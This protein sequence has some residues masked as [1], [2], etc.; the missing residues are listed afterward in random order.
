MSN[1]LSARKLRGDYKLA[2]VLIP[3]A[4]NVSELVKL[5][6]RGSVCILALAADLLCRLF[7]LG[8]LP[9]NCFMLLRRVHVQAWYGRLSHLHRVQSLLLQHVA[10]R[11][12]LLGVLRHYGRCGHWV[13]QLR[14]PALSLLLDEKLLPVLVF[15]FL[16]YVCKHGQLGTC[17]LIPFLVV[18]QSCRGLIL[19]TFLRHFKSWEDFP[20]HLD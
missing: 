13:A 10:E 12:L 5:G 18:I 14:L 11:C 15:R 2:F 7:L 8:L 16:H 6:L 20:L 9:L 17:L 19:D 3:C 1:D 4:I